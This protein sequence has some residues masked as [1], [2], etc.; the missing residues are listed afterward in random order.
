MT[1]EE[2]K[3]LIR[4]VIKI[5]ARYDR[6]SYQY[7]AYAGEPLWYLHADPFYNQTPLPIEDVLRVYNEFYAGQG[8][9]DVWEKA[10]KLWQK[11]RKT[12]LEVSNPEDYIDKMEV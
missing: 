6:I 1:V 9:L 12:L 4:E 7:S 5:L 11:R 2:R 8:I 3:M 10:L